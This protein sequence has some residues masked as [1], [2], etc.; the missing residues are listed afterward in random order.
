MVFNARVRCHMPRQITSRQECFIAHRAQ[1]IAYTDMD[2]LMRLEI[3]KCGELFRTN[4]ALQ[5]FLSSM[6]PAKKLTLRIISLIG[7]QKRAERNARLPN[8]NF[9]IMFLCKAPGARII[10]ANVGLF[11]GMCANVNCKLC[12]CF[13]CLVAFIASL[14]HFHLWLWT[15]FFLL[16]RLFLYVAITISANFKMRLVSIANC[17]PQLVVAYRIP[18]CEFQL[19]TSEIIL[20]I[21]IPLR[22]LGLFLFNLIRLLQVWIRICV[23][24]IVA[25][26]VALVK[27]S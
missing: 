3:T 11:S 26:T 25:R 22:C 27:Q 6:R 14:W 21:Q 10:R 12:S 5:W 23:G 8:M 1:L 18:L 24:V 7:Q 17:L 9:Q 13:E 20:S 19:L 16:L 4:L 2:F 15:A